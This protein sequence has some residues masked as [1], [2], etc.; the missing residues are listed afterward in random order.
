MR[1]Q[2]ETI[3]TGKTGEIYREVLGIPRTRHERSVGKSVPP[4]PHEFVKQF[5]SLYEAN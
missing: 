1:S 5:W 3:L 2:I 4:S